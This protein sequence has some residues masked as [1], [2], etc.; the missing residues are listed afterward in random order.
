MPWT[1]STGYDGLWPMVGDGD[2]MPYFIRRDVEVLN[3]LAQKAV[4]T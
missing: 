2:L 1:K 4:A 3:T